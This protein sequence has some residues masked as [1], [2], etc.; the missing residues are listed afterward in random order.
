P[1]DPRLAAL[2]RERPGSWLDALEAASR[3]AGKRL[4]SFR[5]WPDDLPLDMVEGEIVPRPGLRAIHVVGRQI[6]AY[7]SWRKAVELGRWRDVDTTGTRLALDIDH[8]EQW[9]NRMEGWYR[10]WRELLARRFLPCP[11]VRYEI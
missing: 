4:L 8:F 9:L 11:V 7:V 5:L 6:D 1:D 10:H 3:E 2:I